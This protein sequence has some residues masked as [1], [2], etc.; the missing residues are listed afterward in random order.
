MKDQPLSTMNCKLFCF[1][2]LNRK[3]K[4]F[5]YIRYRAI[6]CR[7]EEFCVCM[8]KLKICNIV[9]EL[10]PADEIRLHAV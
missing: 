7:F 6:F 4:W 3:D 8:R 5:L 1:S 2:L 10:L 9:L